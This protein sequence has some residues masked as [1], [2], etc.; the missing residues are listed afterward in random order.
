MNWP[1]NVSLYLILSAKTV[2]FR[3]L[4]P[5]W[6]GDDREMGFF[7]RPITPLILY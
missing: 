2:A 1:I 7:K 6:N 5:I 3:Q 4:F